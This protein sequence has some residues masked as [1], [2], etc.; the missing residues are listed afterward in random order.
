MRCPASCF[1]SVPCN[2]SL[3]RRFSHSQHTFCLFTL[4]DAVALCLKKN[5]SKQPNVLATVQNKNRLWKDTISILHKYVCNTRYGH[6]RWDAEKIR[7]FFEMHKRILY[8][9]QQTTKLDCDLSP[10]APL[11]PLALF[12]QIISE[13]FLP[14]LES[15]CG[16]VSWL[17]MIV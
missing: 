1:K 4:S 15:I 10:L 16:L 11:A 14:L 6:Y 13:M 17:D 2:C 8:N 12:L 3:K 5:H 9:I 7:S